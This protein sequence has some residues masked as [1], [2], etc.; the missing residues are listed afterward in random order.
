MKKFTLI[1]AACII[2][3]TAVT[4][5]NYFAPLQLKSVED[6]LHS[7]A[8]LL[9]GAP[10]AVLQ[11]TPSKPAAEQQR[12]VGYH[13]I[14][15]N[16]AIGSVIAQDSST[17]VY[18]GVRGTKPSTENYMPVPSSKYDTAFQYDP[19]A[20]FS[21]VK[22]VSSQQYNDADLLTAR[23]KRN[24][25]TDQDDEWLTQAYYPDNTLMQYTRMQYLN[26]QHTDYIYTYQESNQAGKLINDTLMQNMPQAESYYLSRKRNYI[27]DDNNRLTSGY[28][29]LDNLG[30]NENMAD[31]Y[32]INGFFY[33]NDASENYYK[34][35]SYTYY[36]MN[37]GSIATLD[38]V[39]YYYYD[40]DGRLSEKFSIRYDF[41]I[42]GDS[43]SKEFYTY[44]ETGN[45]MQVLGLTSIGDDWVN[46]TKKNYEYTSGL[47]SS[48]TEYVWEDNIWKLTTRNTYHINDQQLVDTFSIYDGN[49]GDPI[50][51]NLVAGGMLSYRQTF[52]Y[53]SFNNLDERNTYNYA[54]QYDGNGI[55][56][57]SEENSATQEL[58][59]Y[60]SYDDG[61]A[62]AAIP[63][64][65]IA[66]QVYPNP[67]TGIFTV[68][69]PTE[70]IR[71][72]LQANVYDMT[73]R[74]MLQ[75]QILKAGTTL[76]LR[77]AGKGIYTLRITN[78]DGSKNY[79]QSIVI[80]H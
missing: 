65:N 2:S 47:I 78:N 76:N 6:L 52:V 30:S 3:A 7:N 41:D 4:A 66:V 55:I 72:G 45:L 50:A 14:Q 36:L 9:P 16:S 32:Y 37:N 71:N 80:T 40:T 27:Y 46:L 67:S 24:T 60:T 12:M 5:Q 22:Y 73:G 29:Y 59:Y 21:S 61:S 33:Y 20:D 10:A 39:N 34:D 70:E 48:E 13:S 53:N 17:Y 51:P 11:Q 42:L 58:F 31:Y 19:A 68:D 74:L 38:V 25:T 69:I 79:A 57:G 15:T 43:T 54:E 28:L 77:S 75:Q 26:E 35:S 8:D 1:V 18:G 23:N 62:I 63:A 56:I 64:N 49:Y 44:N